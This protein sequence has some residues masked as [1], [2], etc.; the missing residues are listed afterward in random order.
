MNRIIVVITMLFL[1]VDTGFS[2]STIVANITG[3]KSDKGVC[4][5]CLFTNEESFK[6][7]A[8]QPYQCGIVTIKNNT[9]Q[10]TFNN[11]AAGSYALFV[12]HDVN[13]NNKMDKNFFGIP[14]EGY[15]AS[16]NK[17]PFAAAPNFNDNKFSVENKTIVRLQ[18]KIRNL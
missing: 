5:A 17:L 18:V 7:G 15:G 8:E 10:A 14:K 3:L 2:Q 16:R 9:A 11:I 6:G 13:N 1:F 12:F 4:R